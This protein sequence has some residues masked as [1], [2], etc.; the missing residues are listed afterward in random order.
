MQLD[1]VALRVQAPG[2]PVR[3]RPKAVELLALLARRPGQTLTKREIQDEL[4]PDRQ[5]EEKNLVML[6]GEIRRALAPFHDG[7]CV[8][9]TIPGRGY[10]LALPVEPM[11]AP[12]VAAPRPGSTSSTSNIAPLAAFRPRVL[13][14]SPRVPSRGHELADAAAAILD[15]LVTR[16]AAVA[17]V[18]V[19]SPLADAGAAGGDA[20]RELQPDLVLASSLLEERSQLRINLQV[21]DPLSRS[22][23][24]ADQLTTERDHLFEAQDRLGERIAGRIATLRTASALDADAEFAGTRVAR[25]YRLGA[26]FLGRRTADSLAR[27]REFFEL[28][29]RQQ[30][31]FAPALAALAHTWAV[32]PY[33]TNADPRECATRAVDCAT[34]ALEID[35]RISQA[36][37]ASGFAQLSVLEW[38]PAADSLRR[39][40][41]LNGRDIDAHHWYSEYLVCSGRPEEAIRSMRAA[42]RLDPTSSI[43][44]SDLGKMLMLA[45]RFDEAAAQFRTTL[46]LDPAFPLAYYRLGLTLAAQGRYREAMETCSRA[47]AFPAE[48]SL[49][50]ALRAY[51]GAV[52]GEREEAQSTL[53]QLRER[54]DEQ[55]GACYGLALLHLGLGEKQLALESLREAVRRRAP[56]SI[57]ALVDPLLDG[58][59]GLR[60]FRELSRDFGVPA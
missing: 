25:A 41:A 48:A 19:S 5:V 23:L 17:T 51:C 18:F 8:V 58:L 45:R 14:L 37:S 24:W 46:E 12:Q 31:R 39:A 59:R 1:P 42:L 34:R 11:L 55:P 26:H 4:W 60:G 57:Y 10:R 30:E 3:L 6:V 40:L 7:L 53:R 33:Y 16:I 35:P 29:L 20:A 22:V 43:L 2:G 36:L 49:Y 21:L 9:A 13:V 27:A 56:L 52:S 32:L 44:N 28:A 47:K 54:T 50:S 15:S 38:Q